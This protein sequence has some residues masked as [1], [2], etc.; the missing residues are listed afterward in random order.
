[1]LGRRLALSG[2]V[3]GGGKQGAVTLLCTPESTPG[4]K[5][6][7]SCPGEKQRGP[8]FPRYAWLREC[9]TWAILEPPSVG[10]RH[11]VCLLTPHSYGHRSGRKPG[12]WA[13][14]DGL[15]CCQLGPGP[16]ADGAGCRN[17]PGQVTEGSPGATT[18]SQA[19]M[20]LRTAQR[21]TC[22]TTPTRLH[23]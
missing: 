20:D 9:A 21:K 4:S 3:C 1:M 17:G 2:G 14:T 19:H 5:S 8:G 22:S 15:P 7:F 11:G 10:P 6:L 12:S 16:E 23:A 18:D 13:R